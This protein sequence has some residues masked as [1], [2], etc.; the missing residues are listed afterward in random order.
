MT[1]DLAC[2]SPRQT[3]PADAAFCQ[4]GKILTERKAYAEARA[5][6]LRNAREYYANGTNSNLNV[7]FLNRLLRT[8]PVAGAQGA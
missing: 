3:L 2:F 8:E 7:T 6:A 5:E 4:I 1:G